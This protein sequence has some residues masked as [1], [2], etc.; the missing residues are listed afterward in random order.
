M[1]TF[2]KILLPV[3]ICISACGGEGGTETGNTDANTIAAAMGSI[4]GNDSESA[5]IVKGAG[6]AR[7]IEKFVRQAK[8]QSEQSQFTACDSVNSEQ[9]DAEG[10][11]TSPDIE[12][13]EYGVPGNSVQVTDEDGCDQG[14]EYA[15]FTVTSHSFVC[16][17]QSTGEQSNLTMDTGTGIWRENLGTNS[18]EIY[19]TF[20]MTSDSGTA[21][22]IR[23]SLTITHDEGMEGGGGS[24]SGD[25]VDSNDQEIEQVTDTIC[26]D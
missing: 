22:G 20:N 17:E 14:G 3:L 2:F 4:F 7:L 8:A 21:V 1:K 5:S 15:G 9:V 25:C 10:V 18:T 19:G 23:C 16:I 13:G 26:Q 11:V 24:F 6:I 12:A